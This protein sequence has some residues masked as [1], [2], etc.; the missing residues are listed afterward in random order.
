MKLDIGGISILT[1]L[2]LKKLKTFFESMAHRLIQG[3]ARYGKPHKKKK[4]L[5]RLKLEINAYDKT[6]N[7]E[8]L[9]NVANYCWLELMAPEHVNHHLDA[10]VESVTRTKI[11][12]ARTPMDAWRRQYE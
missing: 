2:Q 5:T 10:T 6:G 12:D 8:H 3:D 11:K 1:E 7:A 9:I 4:Y